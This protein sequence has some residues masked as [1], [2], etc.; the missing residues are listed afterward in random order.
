MFVASDRSTV[1]VD[2]GTETYKIGYSDNGIPTR[3]GSSSTPFY[4]SPVQESLVVD[5]P[6]YLRI[7]RENIP[8]DTA[9][10]CISENTFD[11]SRK[12]ILQY[13][14]EEDLC[15]SVLFMKSGLLDSFSY[16][17]Y[18][19]LV[20]SIS[21]GSTQVCSVVNGMITDKRRFPPMT[22]EEGASRMKGI[23]QLVDNARE[24][25]EGLSEESKG[26]LLSNI[27]IAGGGSSIPFIGSEVE[28]KMSEMFRGYKTRVI[29]R[30]SRFHSFF[31]GVVF[32]NIGSTRLLHI[33]KMDYQ[34]YGLS[35]LERK[36]YTWTK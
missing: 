9:Y 21:G 30:E 36:N 35:I 12:G 31:G 33:G 26:I 2:I 4:S 34:E 10:L 8:E 23:S 11:D 6:G 24:I 27:L 1:V 7:L 3:F 32:S 18:N 22:K 17:K 14:M 19:A 25:V 20:M 5:L 28:K 13:I 16:G 15:A 29:L